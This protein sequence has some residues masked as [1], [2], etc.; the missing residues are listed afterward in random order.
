MFV[1]QEK[2]QH[3]SILLLTVFNGKV[4]INITVL[5]SLYIIKGQAVPLQAWRGPEGSRK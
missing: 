2:P 4:V 1:H 5:L 3:G